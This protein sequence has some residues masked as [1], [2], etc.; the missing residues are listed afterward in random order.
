M[1]ANHY[2]ISLKETFGSCQDMFLDDTLSL[3]RLLSDHIDPHDFIPVEFS[4]A[5]YQ[6]LGRKRIYPLHGFLCVLILQKIFSIPTDSLIILLLSI[7]RELRDFCGFSK[8]PDAPLFTRFKQ[9][10][11]PCPDAYY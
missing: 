7:C 10:F 11:L 6:S 2:Q 5:F 3:F 1:A 4:S 9:N 8:V